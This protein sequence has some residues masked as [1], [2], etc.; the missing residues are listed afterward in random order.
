[1]HYGTKHQATHGT[2]R[3]RHLH[4]TG[5]EVTNGGPGCL[6]DLADVAITK[7]DAREHGQRPGE[8]C[9]AGQLC[10]RVLSDSPF[11]SKWPR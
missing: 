9:P 1:V 10:P 8:T 3:T 4:L 2:Q 5:R 6:E 11:M 7:V